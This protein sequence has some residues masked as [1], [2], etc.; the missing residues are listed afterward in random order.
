[1]KI[2]RLLSI[3]VILLERKKVPAPKLA[4]IFEVTTR[5]IYRDID[6][7]NAAGIPIITYPGVNG[8]VGIL[9]EFKIEKNLFTS[10]DLA[11]L[12][13]GLS[14]INSTFSSSEITN[15][16]IKLKGIIPQK[17]LKE[18]EQKT[19]RI[20]IDITPWKNSNN[21]SSDLKNIK[22]AMDKNKILTFKYEDRQRKKS[23]R[24]IEPYR[25]IL[26]GSD[27]YVEGFCILRED[28]RYFKLSRISGLKITNKSFI[29]REI[30]ESDP[31]N[32]PIQEKIIKMKVS[33][34]KSLRGEFSELYGEKCFLSETESRYTAE[35]PFADNEYSYRL[36]MGFIDK[37][38]ILEPENIRNEFI[39][40][41]KKA[42]NLY[43][44][45]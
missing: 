38:E 18:I 13:T 14:S 29:P 25:I 24:K 42:A 8:G 37:C 33:V 3:I 27:W 12:L 22:S 41:I 16:L 1:M 23:T 39:L 32:G 7:L 43:K 40:R 9:E 44:Q 2:E 28:F 10:E 21:V 34:D 31:E 20:I 45:K 4:E 15:A 30:P 26:K 19:N 35:I 5:T 6:T 36:L 17:K 11:S